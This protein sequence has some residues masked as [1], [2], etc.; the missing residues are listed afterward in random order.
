MNEQVNAAAW[1][2]IPCAVFSKDRIYR[3]SLLRSDRTNAPLIKRAC[4]IMLNPSTADEVK[5]DPTVER[6]WRRTLRMNFT[7]MEV[8]NLFAL[9]STDPDAL[10]RVHDPVGPLN[11]DW[12]VA[13]GRRADI[14][15][16]AWGSNHSEIGG[17]CYAVVKLLKA[18]GVKLAALKLN[19][20][21]HPAHPLYLSYKLPPRSWE[22]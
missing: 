21:G 10:K 16:C 18:A 19:R 20:D 11:D 1:A 22:G 15:I 4:F 14:T 6:C 13:A 2:G 9:R 5:N 8:V 7:E 12:I 3:Y 17:R